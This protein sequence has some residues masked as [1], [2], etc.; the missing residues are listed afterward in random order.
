MGM[1]EGETKKGIKKNA[2]F[3]L[4]TNTSLVKKGNIGM[5]SGVQ[6]NAGLFEKTSMER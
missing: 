1:G 4:W 5:D 2:C 6:V 3:S